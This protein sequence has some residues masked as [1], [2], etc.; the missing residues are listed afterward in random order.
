MPEVRDT[1]KY[2]LKVGKKVVHIGHTTDLR[3]REEEHQKH[4]PE[5][6]IYQVGRRTTREEARQWERST[7]RSVEIEPKELRTLSYDTRS[8]LLK[9]KERIV[10]ALDKR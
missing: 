9:N 3:R 5:S 10:R 6:K 4:W 1:Y 2:K 7:L 8:R